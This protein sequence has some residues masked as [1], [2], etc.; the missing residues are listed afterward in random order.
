MINR[1][2]SAVNQHY[3]NP[4]KTTAMLPI[5]TI[6]DTLLTTVHM[7]LTEFCEHYQGS[8]N[9]IRK[10]AIAIFKAIKN[11]TII[12]ENT[13]GLFVTDVL[14]L[15]MNAG[16]PVKIENLKFDHHH[17]EIAEVPTVANI[18]TIKGLEAEAV[19]AIAK[20]EA[21]LLL[22][23]EKN[24]TIRDTKRT[25]ETTDYPRLGYVAFSRAERLHCIA[26]LEKVAPTTLTLLTD[27][28]VIKFGQRAESSELP[29]LSG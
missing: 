10:H 22:R 3:K 25:N 11:G 12:N 4:K 14:K 16:L 6:Q 13:Y 29:K 21:E 19:L 24:H 7:N 9:T 26:C 28:G 8:V 15:K 20:T 2:I 17:E 18:H 5:K 23:L 1:I 27:L